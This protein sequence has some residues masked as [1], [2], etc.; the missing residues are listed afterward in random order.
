MGSSLNE[1][2]LYI[3]TIPKMSTLHRLE[4]DMYVYKPQFRC[5]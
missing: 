3:L 2:Y 1:L 4:L 5:Y